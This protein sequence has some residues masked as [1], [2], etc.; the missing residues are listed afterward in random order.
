MEEYCYVTASTN[1]W[2]QTGSRENTNQKY[3]N[4][5][6]KTRWIRDEEHKRNNG[7]TARLHF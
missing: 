7:S 2:S 4:Y 1:P 6:N 5:P 3:N